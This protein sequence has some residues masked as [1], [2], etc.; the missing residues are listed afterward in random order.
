M[1]DLTKITKERKYLK[2]GLSQNTVNVANN[3]M[4]EPIIFN[5]STMCRMQPIKDI[6]NK[7][8]FI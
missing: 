5:C 7:I 8:Y 6:L 1:N 3:F 4:L 2:P